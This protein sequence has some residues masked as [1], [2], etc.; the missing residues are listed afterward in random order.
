MRANLVIAAILGLGACAH[1]SGKS[2]E[3]AAAYYPLAVGNEWTYVASMGPGGPADANVKLGP[4]GG[5]KTIRIVKKDG[6]G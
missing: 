6:E 4:G 2:S 5:E 3:P 1:K